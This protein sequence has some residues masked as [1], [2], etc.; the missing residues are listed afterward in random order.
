MS[1]VKGNFSVPQVSPYNGL[2]MFL[3]F[4]FKR[5]IAYQIYSIFRVSFK[6]TSI[7]PASSDDNI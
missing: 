6:Y 4:K 5:F 2:F 3:H 7:H 1:S